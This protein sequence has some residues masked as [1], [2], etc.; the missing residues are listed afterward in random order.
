[1]STDDSTIT[2]FELVYESATKPNFALSTKPGTDGLNIGA[3]V[4]C[5][6]TSTKLQLNCTR[7]L[8]NPNSFIINTTTNKDLKYNQLTYTPLMS[9]I[10][11]GGTY[12]NIEEVEVSVEVDGG[13]VCGSECIPIEFDCDV[14]G[15]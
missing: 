1:M 13:K 7:P 12:L 2:Q 8:E 11:G 4:Q 9:V 3:L 15:A 14:K 5:D 6:T 10:N